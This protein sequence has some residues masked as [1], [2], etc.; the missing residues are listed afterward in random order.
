MENFI[1]IENLKR[2]R[3]AL[4]ETTDDRKRKSLIEAIRNEM[5]KNQTDEIK[6]SN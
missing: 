5:A 1:H 4:S 6:A 2:Y 3:K